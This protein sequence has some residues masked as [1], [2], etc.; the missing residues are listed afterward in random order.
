MGSKTVKADG[1]VTLGT[2]D[3]STKLTA[4]GTAVENA[5]K[6]TGATEYAAANKTALETAITTATTAIDKALGDKNISK[7]ANEAFTTLKNK[8]DD[9]K[10]LN[11]NASGLKNDPTQAKN[12]ENVAKLN[13][14]KTGIEEV[15]AAFEE[16]YAITNSQMTSLDEL[17][18]TLQGFVAKP[19][20]VNL[21]HTSFTTFL[22]VVDSSLSQISDVRAKLGASQNRLEY[23]INNLEISSENLT[24]AN[25]R[26]EDADMA[27]EMMNFII[28]SQ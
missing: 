8:L 2:A 11:T 15:T 6:T 22:D 1:T 18:T 19:N 3:L 27:K 17:R 23:T 4:A 12:D 10:T 9:L 28:F 13:A 21:D 14:L 5:L 24:S 20:D 25:S 26:I 16:A 7:A